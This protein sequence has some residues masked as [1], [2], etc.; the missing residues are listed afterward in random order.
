[1][2]DCWDWGISEPWRTVRVSVFGKSVWREP[3]TDYMLPRQKLLLVVPLLVIILAR[4]T[5]QHPSGL[6]GV[7]TYAFDHRPVRNVYVLVH[8]NGSEDAHTRIDEKGEFTLPLDPGVYDVLVSSEGFDPACR[9]VEVK[10]DGMMI[11]NVS[12]KATDV[13]VQTD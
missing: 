12:L 10:P 5:A 7:V 13:G 4:A 11:Y 3:Y 9:K 2:N 1:M 6:R 8:R